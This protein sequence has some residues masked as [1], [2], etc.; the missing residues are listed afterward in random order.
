MTEQD[1]IRLQTSVGPS[2]S[3]PNSQRQIVNRKS[4]RV[5][6][7]SIRL[8]DDITSVLRSSA[9]RTTALIN[10]G[11]F[12]F[13]TIMNYKKTEGINEQ[14]GAGSFRK[15]TGMPQTTRANK[16]LSIPG[17]VVN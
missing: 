12:H 5:M 13:G 15:W 8:K 11:T 7:R 17:I 6:N 14:A 4:P 3:R 2:S 16:K 1:S 9:D 10:S